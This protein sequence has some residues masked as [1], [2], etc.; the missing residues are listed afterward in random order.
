MSRHTSTSYI[1]RHLDV[2]AFLQLFIL[3]LSHYALTPL[4]LSK[5]FE[6]HEYPEIHLLERLFLLVRCQIYF[7]L[8]SL[9]G[10][11]STIEF[12][13][14]SRVNDHS[15]LDFMSHGPWLPDPATHIFPSI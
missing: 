2:L 9:Q 12:G 7:F 1:L 6:N 4:P 14:W 5:Q 3:F 8:W 13:Y 15:F 10:E 11:L